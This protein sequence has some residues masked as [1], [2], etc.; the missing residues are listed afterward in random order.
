MERHFDLNEPDCARSA[1]RYGRKD[2]RSGRHIL[3]S[4]L[5]FHHLFGLYRRRSVS[6]TITT[7]GTLSLSSGGTAAS[8]WRRGI[9]AM[10]RKHGTLYPVSELHAFIVSSHRAER[11]YH[12]LHVLNLLCGRE[13]ALGNCATLHLVHTRN[14]NYL[15]CYFQH[16]LC[17]RRHGADNNAVQWITQFIYLSD[18]RRNS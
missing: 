11:L 8:L 9:V 5:R 10:I 3:S 4:V 6:P 17:L 16:V 1:I 18:E 14:F 12:Q 7:T 2:R 13:R 15:D